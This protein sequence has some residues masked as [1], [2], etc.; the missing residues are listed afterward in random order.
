MTM[1]LITPTYAPD[2]ELFRH[3]HDSVRTH[4]NAGALHMA[5]V[6]RVD[7]PLFERIK[8]DRLVLRTAEDFLPDHWIPLRRLVGR[9]PNAKLRKLQY[10]NIRRPYM[11]VRGWI[12]QQLL[13]LAAASSIDSKVALLVDSDV[14]FFRDIREEALEVG[15]AVR[16]YAAPDGLTEGMLE[17]HRWRS[18]ARRLLGL[19]RF[20]YADER[21]DY[22][23]GLVSWSPEL[24]RMLLDDLA[25]TS[26]RCWQDIL[27]SERSFSECFL[28][29]EYA[30]VHPSRVYN[31]SSSLCVSYWKT[32]ALSRE[33]VADLVGQSSASAY[34]VQIQSTSGT[35]LD[36]RQ[37]IVRTLRERWRDE[38][39][40]F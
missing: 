2:F 40:G 19:S 31:S 29:G 11:P 35:P 6:P 16:L 34:A 22:V 15:E 20:G 21:T 8:S 27:A 7:L 1:T 12:V 9:L 37:D 38:S 30:Q 10:L 36:V 14:C 28:Y 3:L 18:V 25:G 26:E 5:I 24:T 39:S 23:S 13:K 33:G 32:A 17:Q 4:V